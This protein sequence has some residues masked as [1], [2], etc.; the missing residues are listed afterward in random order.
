MSCLILLTVRTASAQ[1][2]STP[3]VPEFTVKFVNDSYYVPPTYGVD[4]YSGKTVQTGGGFAW[5]NETIQI[6]IINPQPFTVYRD[7]DGN[8]I[9]L[10]YNVEYKGHFGQS[11]MEDEV[12]H[13]DIVVF[14]L[15]D[16]GYDENVGAPFVPLGD[17]S[18]G[19]QVDFRVQTQ[20]GYYNYTWT[21]VGNDMSPSDY[22][23]VFI[24]K[25]SAWSSVQTFA[26]PETS[27]STYSSS[28]PTQS[29]TSTPTTTLILSPTMTETP[30]LSQ[31]VPELSWLTIVPLLLF[32][33]SVAVIVRRRKQVKK[34]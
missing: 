24:G 29:P 14:G 4:Q 28:D 3:L 19:D 6:I 30:T 8:W 1:T 17:L 5:F 16:S 27:I 11:W 32:V 26:M 21:G 2:V 18:A 7:Q 10:Y 13:G 23:S 12:S 22:T 15:G 33:F 25:S 9:S 31:S 34:V 20:I